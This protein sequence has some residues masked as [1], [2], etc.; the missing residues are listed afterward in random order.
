M[1]FTTSCLGGLQRRSG[2]V[3]VFRGGFE[4]R[5]VFEITPFNAATRRRAN[6]TRHSSQRPTEVCQVTEMMIRH[7]V[8]FN[9]SRGNPCGEQFQRRGGLALPE[10]KDTTT[11]P[12]VT[13][14]APGR[15]KRAATPR[16]DWLR[17][18]AL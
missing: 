1:L 5:T 6:L 16:T 3:D 15:S 12:T 7:H 13:L 14:A 4:V 17:V 10:C 18:N 9:V 2:F 8:R 11:G